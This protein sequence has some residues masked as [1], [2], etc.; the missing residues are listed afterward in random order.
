MME[1]DLKKCLK[2]KEEYLDGWKRARA[3]FINYKKEEEKRVSETLFFALSGTIIK[4]LPILDE[5]ERAEKET[6]EQGISQIRKKFEHLLND[7]GIKEM[8]TNGKKFDPNFHEAVE[9]VEAK[10]KEKGTIME[11]I[12]KGYL[13]DN[14]ILRPAKVKVSK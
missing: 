6:K 12:Q 14:H 7:F 4:I 3:D 5:L 10:D 9:Q 11:E 13:I 8:E 2:Q 1:D